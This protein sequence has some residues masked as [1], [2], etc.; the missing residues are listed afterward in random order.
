MYLHLFVYT[1]YL[2]PKEALEK[3][4]GSALGALKKGLGRITGNRKAST[5]S[6]ATQIDDGLDWE[7]TTILEYL[8]GPKS[9]GPGKYR[10]SQTPYQNS[11]LTDHELNEK[12]KNEEM[13]LMK[14]KQQADLLGVLQL[15]L[16]LLS[17]SSLLLSL[18]L[19]L[20]SLSLS[21]SSLLLSRTGGEKRI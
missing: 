15:L 19:S 14:E 3:K 17:L 16:S 20:L 7:D 6:A 8:E 21:L 2:H 13:Q 11:G 18:L 5:S 9:G 4:S 1:F 12:R 10:L